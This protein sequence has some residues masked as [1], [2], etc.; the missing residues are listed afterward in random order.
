MARRLRVYQKPGRRKIV[1]ACSIAVS[2]G[3]SIFVLL[4]T[5]FKFDSI[6]DP[7]PLSLSLQSPQLISG[8]DGKLNAIYRFAEVITGIDVE[9]KISAISNGASI[10]NI[11]LPSST[12]G[13]SPAFQPTVTF[14]SGTSSNPVT[15]YMEFTLRFKKAGTSTDT[16]VSS[17]SATA[18][19]IDGNNRILESVEA[20]TPSSYS[21]NP[22]C[23]LIINQFSNSVRAEAYGEDFGGIDSSNKEVMFQM[24]FENVSSLRY[25]VRGTNK[26]SA[27]TRQS[28]IYFK[29]FFTN[30]VTLP[31][32]L[33][34]FSAEVLDNTH[35]KLKWATES[36]INNDFF[37]IERSKSG[38][39]YEKLHNVLGAGNSTVRNEYFFIDN[40]PL[41]GNVFYRLRQTDYDGKNKVFPPVKVN[42]KMQESAFRISDVFPNPFVKAVQVNLVSDKNEAVQMLLISASGVVVKEQEVISCKGKCIFWLSD[43]DHLPQGVYFLSAKQSGLRSNTVTLL[44]HE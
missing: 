31:V 40:S 24:N 33:S 3:V 35:V 11:D 39:D 18:I 38:K 30:P 17:I 43:L 5:F 27:V 6:A 10:S 21:T 34:S 9:V 7:S 2:F 28:S 4:N 37:T 22:D 13:Y 42:I 41:E 8:V 44:K 36:E 12:T 25:R 32:E 1:V 16:I 14:A 29:G 26:G 23:K 20:F 19:D 15:S